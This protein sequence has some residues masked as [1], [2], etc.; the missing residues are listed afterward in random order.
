MGTKLLKK[1]CNCIH[2]QEKQEQINRSG[3]YWSRILAVQLRNWFL[4][5]II[6]N[7]LKKLTIKWKSTSLWKINS[8][9]LVDIAILFT[10]TVN[11]IF[12]I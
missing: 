10:I 1:Q 4:G 5:T 12:M 3:M 8:H 6:M 9:Y 11:L 7:S 2:C